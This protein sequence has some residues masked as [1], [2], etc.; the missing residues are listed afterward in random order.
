[1]AIHQQIMF[2]PDRAPGI[3]VEQP[4]EPG[5]PRLFWDG[6]A[7][8][9]TAEASAR[10]EAVADPTMP[11]LYL[12]SVPSAQSAAWP[13]K[14]YWF[15]AIDPDTGLLFD[16]W[17]VSVV[18]GNDGCQPATSAKVPLFGGD[19]LHLWGAYLDMGA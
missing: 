7:G 12:V 19:S 1:L 18:G 16:H 4:V 5:Q 15:A 17:P 9:W 6:K 13:A 8:T 11:G 2:A 3:R 10:V 14:V